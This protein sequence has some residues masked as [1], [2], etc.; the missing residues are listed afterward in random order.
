M[1]S[2]SDPATTAVLFIECQNGLLGPESLLPAIRA[3]ALPKVA[4]MGRL[5][6]GARAAGATVVHLTA[7]PMRGAR[8]FNRRT[9]LFQNLMDSL[10]D[11]ECGHPAVQPID[12]IGVGPNDL[13][14]PRATGISPTYGNETFKVLRNLGIE[15]VVFAGISVNIAITVSAAQAADED[16]AVIVAR[17]AAAGA[18]DDYA[19]AMFRN[20]LSMI[21]RLHTVDELVSDWTG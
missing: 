7:V 21:A 5:A 1:P 19:E 2:L 17:D 8:T 16:F 3:G 14:L 12:E 10:T 15:T 11:W 13:V 9:P 18:P 20:T 4:A 6:A